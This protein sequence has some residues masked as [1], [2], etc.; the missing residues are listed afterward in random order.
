MYIR[1]RCSAGV[2]CWRENSPG[3]YRLFRWNCVYLPVMEV[4]TLFSKE[5][6]CRITEIFHLVF[7]WKQH[8]IVIT[9]KK[10]SSNLAFNVEE[11]EGFCSYLLYYQSLSVGTETIDQNQVYLNMHYLIKILEKFSKKCDLLMYIDKK[12]IQKSRSILYPF[13][14][15]NLETLLLRFESVAAL[16]KMLTY[17]F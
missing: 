7:Y 4:R 9:N 16:M 3:V 5:D 6:V 13:K 17:P 2:G 10:G 15:F 1:A 12:H 11:K 8:V 14:F